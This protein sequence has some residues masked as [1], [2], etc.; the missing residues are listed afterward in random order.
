MDA[1]T[2][3]YEFANVHG[4]DVAAAHQLV[5]ALAQ[6]AYPDRGAKFHPIAADTLALPSFA[7]YDVYQ[8][9][10]LTHE[11]WREVITHAND[12]L[13]PVWIEAADLS[14]VQV[15]VA[16]ASR[17][18]G[19]KLQ[20]SVLENREVLGALSAADLS[21]MTLVLNVSGQELSAIAEVVQRFSILG[22]R[23][24]AL[25]VG[26]QNYPT[27]VEDSLLNKLAV[28]RAAFPDLELSFSD[29]VAGGDPFALRV[30]LLATALGCTIIE[31]H[32]CLD[33]VTAPYDG[34]AALEPAEVAQLAGELQQTARA[35]SPSFI[36]PNETAYLVSTVQRPVAARALAAGTLVSE[37]DVLF[38]R[39]DDDGL[40]LAEV[41]ALQSRY[42][43]LAR[44]VA[45]HASLAAGDFRP[46]HVAAMVAG[47]LT[48][49]R[50]P[51][52]ALLEV[53]GRTSVER[54]LDNCLRFPGVQTVVLATS[55]APDDDP[56]AELTLDP[57]VR[58]WRGEADDVIRRYLGAASEWDVDVVVRVTADCL[59]MSPEVTKILLDE[60]F[61]SGADYTRAHRETLGS[62]PQVFSVDA[63]RRIDELTGGATRS[64]YM[65][66]YV[67]NNPELFQIH[68][69]DLPGNLVRPRRLTLDY[70]QDL[71]MYQA[72]Y[73]ELA[74]RGE[75]ADLRNVLAV[76]E[77]RPDIAALNDGIV[78]LY[79]HGPLLDE[80][81]IA[82]RI[83][84]P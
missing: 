43:V 53:A 44:P 41:R 64:E 35:F 50:L 51:R 24:L 67:E 32:V 42:Q 21:D 71:L 38:R 68:W 74:A 36:V 57:R 55:T 80:L 30:P 37:Q 5:D 27:S 56:L 4:G 46:A 70:E 18:Q 69:V 31:K 54:C 7:Y 81:R 40:A 34:S 20:T 61:S 45:P 48:S 72:L 16:N 23:R 15:L 39:T 52:K 58:L 66:M 14:A 77:D 62:A 60:H 9:V 1:P 84:T 82:T 6:V 83:S 47:R 79:S 26:F 2:L 3:I 76:L 8:E 22:T 73:A 33:R 11:E 19:L 59:T 17:V 10:A 75:P 78:P 29:H 12:A 25:Q 49:T 28:L 63:L 13:G 65:N